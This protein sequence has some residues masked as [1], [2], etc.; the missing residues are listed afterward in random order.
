M[1]G[2]SR[3]GRFLPWGVGDTNLS[4]PIERSVAGEVKREATKTCDY[5][6]QSTRDI[7]EFLGQR[8]SLKNT[9]P[10]IIEF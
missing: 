1:A 10:Y 2:P 8:K 9:E 6:L 7:R 3:G 4:I 5:S